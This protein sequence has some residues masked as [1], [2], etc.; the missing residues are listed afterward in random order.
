LEPGLDVRPPVSCI[1]SPVSFPRLRV[2][3]TQRFAVGF[4]YANDFAKSPAKQFCISV[5]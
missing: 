5:L 4:K 3:F 1:L 2:V